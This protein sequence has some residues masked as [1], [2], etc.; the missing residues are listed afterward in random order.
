MAL[1][2]CGM[3]L[4]GGERG[5]KP[6]SDWQRHSQASRA[7]KQHMYQAPAATV[8]QIQSVAHVKRGQHFK[9]STDGH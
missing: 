2:F 1:P 7:D 3:K 4:F 9:A 6:L 5:L 8:D